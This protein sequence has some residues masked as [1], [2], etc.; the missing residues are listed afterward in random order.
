[1]SSNDD[2]QVAE[3][4]EKVNILM[5][6]DQPAKLLSYEVILRDLGENLIK[7]SSA[8]EALEHLL[9]KDI[10]VVLADVRH[11]RHGRV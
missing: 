3:P 7:A 9:K 1:M 4:N 6:D 11:A 8:R 10:A 2:P 5:V